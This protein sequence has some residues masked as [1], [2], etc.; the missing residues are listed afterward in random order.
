[1]LIG[2]G[3]VVSGGMVEHVVYMCIC[4]MIIKRVIPI[5]LLNSR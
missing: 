1:M 3:T 2:T 4:K 5:L